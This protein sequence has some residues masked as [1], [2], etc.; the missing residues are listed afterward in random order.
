M[1]VGG[2]DGRSPAF[3]LVVW[4]AVCLLKT[5]IFKMQ[6]LASKL[7]SNIWIIHTH[8]THTQN[9]TQLSRLHYTPFSSSSLCCLLAPWLPALLFVCLIMTKLLTNISV[10]PSVLGITDCQHFSLPNTSQHLTLSAF[11]KFSL[12]P[13]DHSPIGRTGFLFPPWASL[14]PPVP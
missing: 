6:A 7:K 1:E 5:A 4:L 14:L 12:D 13:G 11:L 8:N 2:G 3:Y 10:N 9:K